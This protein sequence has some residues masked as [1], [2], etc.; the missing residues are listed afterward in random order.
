MHVQRR[1]I[2]GILSGV[3]FLANP[4]FVGCSSKFDFGK[5]DMEQEL[6]GISAT[7]WQ[8]PGYRVRVDLHPPKQG[9]KEG[10]GGCGSSRSFVTDAAACATV[11][12]MDIEGSLAMW[13]ENSGNADAEP[14]VL[15]NGTGRYE[16]FGFKLNEGDLWIGVQDQWFIY[17]ADD[18]DGGYRIQD[19]MLNS[20]GAEQV[21]L[22][23][24]YSPASADPTLGGAGSQ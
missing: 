13:P 5:E 12:T 2:L 9:T 7:Q 11:T 15:V 18:G 19:L 1:L 6:E 8:V 3:F 10:A 20:I 4:A 17:F 14:V 22:N 21:T 16:V 23:Y 24:S